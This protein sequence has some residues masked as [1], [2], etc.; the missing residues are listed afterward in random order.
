M[1]TENKQKKKSDK[2]VSSRQIKYL[3]GLAHTL[4][5]LILIGKEG[6]TDDLI[7]ALKTELDRHELVKVKIGANSSEKKDK[8]AETL[9][10][11]TQSILVQLI[12]KTLI[13]Y[14]ANPKLPKDKRIYLPK[15]TQE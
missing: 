13:L 11:A 2:N 1:K 3:R 6:I 8:A 4:S 7:K 10:A 14:K 9:P 5:A 15:D 12:G